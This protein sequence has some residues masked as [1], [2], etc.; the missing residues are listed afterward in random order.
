MQNIWY[1]ILNF[2]H[3][4]PW[5]QVLGRGQNGKKA[6]TSGFLES[7]AP[8][9]STR[10][11]ARAWAFFISGKLTKTKHVLVQ[12]ISSQKIVTVDLQLSISRQ[13]IF[14]FQLVEWQANDLQE[15][16]LRPE[17]SDW[18]E[19]WITASSSN[20]ESEG[21]CTVVIGWVCGGVKIGTPFSSR[22]G[23]STPAA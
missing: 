13:N 14:P 11:S 1:Y 6:I 9:I 18:R 10:T 4:G 16:Y 21:C 7:N 19:A 12:H 15:N 5:K 20:A 22:G 17:E 23:N 8:S 2:T 3:K